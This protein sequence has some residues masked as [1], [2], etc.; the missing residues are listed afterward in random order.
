MK[1]PLAILLA[2]LVAVSASA[3][4]P[5]LSDIA[6]GQLSNRLVE[7]SYTLSGGR[8]I[9]TPVFKL[10]G[11]PIDMAGVVSLAGDVRRIVAPGARRFVWDPRTD[12][13]GAEIDTARL[14]VEL[15]AWKPDCPPPKVVI[16]LDPMEEST[17]SNILYYVSEAELPGGIADERYRT[18]KLLMTLVPARNVRWRMG[19]GTAAKSKYVTLSKDFFIGVFTFTQ[20]QGE[21]AFGTRGAKR[22]NLV[23]SVLCPMET[24]Y[25]LIRGAKWGREPATDTSYLA[26]L[27]SKTGL[28]FDLPSEFQWEYAMRA[29]RAA[30]FSIDEAAQYGWFGKGQAWG[31]CSHDWC[32][33]DTREA[34]PVGR[35]KPNAFGIYDIIGNIREYT[36]TRADVATAAVSLS[37]AEETDP[38]T[39]GVDTTKSYTVRRSGAH[40]EEIA[41][42][43]LTYRYGI[44]Y[45]T[46]DNECGFRVIFTVEPE[47][48]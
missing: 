32:S 18:T 15:T 11:E 24:K 30:S 5:A 2:S 21:T 28:A 27:S 9:V 10:D 1:A 20:G 36:R 29:G 39:I 4:N 25:R 14:T 26:R 33:R 13:T 47:E 37:T 8:A 6:I 43:Q 23:D 16:D 22:T 17:P 44:W 35:L 7:V 19:D 42:Q 40:Y 31:S 41:Q 3:A 12:W 45:D 46:A 34:H 48:N 38:E